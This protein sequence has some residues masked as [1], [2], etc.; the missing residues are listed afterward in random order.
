M[1]VEYKNRWK[2]SCIPYILKSK[3]SGGSPS[4]NMYTYHTRHENRLIIDKVMSVESWV[5]LNW[6]TREKETIIT[7][8]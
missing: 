8:Q 2:S 3:Q 5:R 1:V 4:K 6:L 7:E